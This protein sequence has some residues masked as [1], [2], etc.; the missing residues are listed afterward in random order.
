[1]LLLLRTAALGRGGRAPDLPEGH[2]RADVEEGEG[3]QREEGG[4]E[5]VEADAVEAVVGR[6]APQGGRVRVV[7]LLLDLLCTLT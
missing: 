7:E 5:G 4:E 2:E 1:M 6:V 3:E